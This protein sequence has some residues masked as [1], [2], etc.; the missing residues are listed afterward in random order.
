MQEPTSEA[1]MYL[2]ELKQKIESYREELKADAGHPVATG[3]GGPVTME[4]IDA[5]MEFLELHEN[6]LIELEQKTERLC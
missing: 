3:P 1:T 2:D 5:L 6:R 4:I